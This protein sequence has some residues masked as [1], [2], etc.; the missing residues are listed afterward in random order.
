M[1]LDSMYGFCKVLIAVFGPEYLREPNVADIA[2]L[3]A[4]NASRGFAGMLGS[5]DYMH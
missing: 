3:F 1:C 5:I 2:W 4:M